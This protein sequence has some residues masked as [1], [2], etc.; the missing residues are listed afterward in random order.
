MREAVSAAIK[1]CGIRGVTVEGLDAMWLLR[2]DDESVQQQ[3]LERGV[4][5]GA[6]FKRGAYNYASLAHGDDE[7]LVELEH[8]ASSAFV[9]VMESSS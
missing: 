1:A 3:F 6:L 9:D 4:T 7:V 8:I 2:F 5:H